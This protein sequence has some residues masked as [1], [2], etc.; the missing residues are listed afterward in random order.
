[1]TFQVPLNSCFSLVTK[2]STVTFSGALWHLH[3]VTFSDSPSFKGFCFRNN[4]ML[5]V[6][7]AFFLTVLLFTLSHHCGASHLS[8]AMC[9]CG[10]GT[11]CRPRANSSCK[12]PVVTFYCD[13]ITHVYSKLV[14]TGVNMDLLIWESILWQ[15]KYYIYQYFSIDLQ[16][17][18]PLTNQLPLYA[19]NRDS[20]MPAIT[21]RSVM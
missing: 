21:L 2:Q 1:M 6:F 15:D 8:G 11:F 20:C 3:Q 5:I 10:R 7:L 16:H 19:Y 14:Q 12:H 4:S 17:T 13:K 9:A 18:A